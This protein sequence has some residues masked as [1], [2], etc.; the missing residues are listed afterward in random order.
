MDPWIVSAVGVGFTL[1]FR[2]ALDA[3]HLAAVAA[4]V[5]DRRRTIAGCSHV[6]LIWGAGHASALLAVSLAV[7]GFGIRL[8]D[9]MAIWM[10]FAVGATL[11]FL[12]ARVAWG[13]GRGAVLHA[14]PHAHGAREHFHPHVHPVSVEAAHASHHRLPAATR[15]L[16]A[17]HGENRRPFVVGAIHGMAGSAALML[18]VM[19]AIPATGA[20]LLYTALFAAGSIGGMVIMSA[21]VGLPFALG[22]RLHGRSQ[23]GLRLA[24]GCL[25]AGFGL[26]MMWSLAP[27]LGSQ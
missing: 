6:G 21:L 20:R 9:R 12:G 26:F 16:M 22:G 11:L 2:H 23:H 25:S 14:H 4:M 5:G 19:T 7:I 27:A 10:E 17:A 3:D 24:A 15:R 13:Y 1:G 18:L 8:P